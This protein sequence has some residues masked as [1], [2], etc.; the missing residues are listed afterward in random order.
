MSFTE[1]DLVVGN[2]YSFN[3]SY[4]ELDWNKWKTYRR[5]YE[6]SINLKGYYL[7]SDNIPDVDIDFYI[8]IFKKLDGDCILYY[9]TL[10][11]IT[12]NP[13]YHD[14][15]DLTYIKNG[16]K[17]QLE[18]PEPITEIELRAIKYYLKLNNCLDSQYYDHL[19]DN[20][21]YKRYSP[22]GK[23]TG[24]KLK[25]I[26]NLIESSIKKIGYFISLAPPIHGK[27]SGGALYKRGL[28][29]FNLLRD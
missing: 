9:E 2:I 28:A 24:K 25:Q 11:Q 12:V 15:Y 3:H 22:K 23:I 10:D 19:I 16:Y 14:D 6:T 17:I 27:F 8:F 29:N 13:V 7:M 20:N 26:V 18:E 21:Y 1:D 5:W 4:L